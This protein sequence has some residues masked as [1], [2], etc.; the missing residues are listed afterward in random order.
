MMINIASKNT[1]AFGISLLAFA[2]STF[3]HASVSSVDHEVAEKTVVS[4]DQAAQLA[5]VKNKLMGQQKEIPKQYIPLPQ[6]QIAQSDMGLIAQKPAL[7]NKDSRKQ[8]AKAPQGGGLQMIRKP[9]TVDE[10]GAENTPTTEILP[11]QAVAQSP[12]Q[13]VVA[14]QV[15]PNPIS[16][17]TINRLSQPQEQAV[18]YK[19]PKLGD[20]QLRKK[21][22]FYQ[23]FYRSAQ[24]YLVP[25]DL[26]IAIAQTESSMTTHAVGK[27]STSED[28]GVMQINTSWLPKLSREFGLK[29]HHLY[30]PCTNI[31]IGAWV[32]AHNFLQFG[33][34]WN[35]VGA[36]NAKSPE[37][38]V[39]YVR[40]VAR[41]L[42]KL[43]RGEL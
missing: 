20:Y 22:Y 26:L 39:V 21:P 23:C 35:A 14:Q 17:E 29:R 33:Y 6:T 9:S 3:S 2:V 10:L 4:S 28:L 27:N 32:L 5:E 34:T 19:V 38:R 40:K 31:D 37:K 41:N 15:N 1:Q 13:P 42:E 18:Q 16:Q 43:R 25:V 8:F 36:Y 12:V 30:E 24:K 11:A 7:L